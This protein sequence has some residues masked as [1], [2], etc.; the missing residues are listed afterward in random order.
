MLL[1][2][3]LYSLSTDSYT[4]FLEYSQACLMKFVADV[5]PDAYSESEMV[6]NTHVLTHLSDFVKDL[7]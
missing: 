6:Y 1:H 4:E 5:L 2:F 3:S 7:E